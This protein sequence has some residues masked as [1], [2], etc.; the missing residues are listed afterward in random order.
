[1][2]ERLIESRDREEKIMYQ[3]DLL[4]WEELALWSELSYLVPL[5]FLLSVMKAPPLNIGDG[6]VWG[7]DKAYDSVRDVEIKQRGIISRMHE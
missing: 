3:L 6:E 4:L 5:W 1:M 2:S 7:R